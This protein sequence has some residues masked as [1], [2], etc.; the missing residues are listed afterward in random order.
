MTNRKKTAEA[1]FLPLLAWRNIWRNKRRTLITLLSIFMAVLL[2]SLMISIQQG[3]WDA[4]IANVLST[5]TGYIQIHQKGYSEDQSINRSFRPSTEIL[6]Q[7]QTHPNVLA[8]LPRL[9]SFAL[10]SAENLS[11]GVLV[12]GVDPEA[13]NANT[14]LAAR[15]SAGKYFPKG[16]ESALL[17]DSL[18]AHLKLQPGDTLVLLSQGYHGMNAAGKYEITGL[19]HFPSPDLNKSLVL[20]PLKTAQTFYGTGEQITSL[21]LFLKPNSDAE[22]TAEELSSQ[23]D[24][25]RYEILA[26]PQ[27]MPE[28]VQ[29]RDVDT[30]GAVLMLLVL[31]LIISFGIFGTLLMMVR[32]RMYEMGVL[33]AIG[34]KRYLLGI[35]FWLEITFIGLLGTLL[36]LAASFPVVYYFNRYPIKITD[37]HRDAVAIYER[38]GFEPIFPASMDPA[39]FVRQALFIFIITSIMAFYPFWTLKKLRVTE[40]MKS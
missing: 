2:S 17:S 13:E 21:A 40:A 29:A 27:M 6:Q 26:W 5:Y 38:F 33:I 37:L 3:A 25:S 31:Y 8:A 4:M 1:L 18:A 12:L 36:G 15:I 16:R 24:T 28:L 39:I 9:E 22:K 30:A 14:K 10:A 20:L 34:M 7:I 19:V 23:V 32:E 35:M 11:R